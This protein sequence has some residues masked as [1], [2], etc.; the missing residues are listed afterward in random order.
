MNGF[1]Q[2]FHAR[3]SA[4]CLVEL[5]IFWVQLLEKQILLINA[6][7]REAPGNALVVSQSHAGESRLARA[8]HI[9]TR[10][11]QVHH[12]A[13]RGKRNSAVRIV[14]HDGTAGG[15]DPAGNGPVV[16]LGCRKFD[17]VIAADDFIQQRRRQAGVVCAS[18][19]V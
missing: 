12:V 5:R 15:S 16:A 13:Q 19:R 14:S 9:P 11:H 10:R 17:A 2:D 6:K 3:P 7:N 1:A 4:S 18:L 8:D